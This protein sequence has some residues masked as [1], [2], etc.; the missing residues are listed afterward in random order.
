[1]IKN[2]SHKLWLIITAVKLFHALIFVGTDLKSEIPSYIIVAEASPPILILRSFFDRLLSSHKTYRKFNYFR[3][4]KNHGHHQEYDHV[5][6]FSKRKSG[7]EKAIWHW[8]V[9]QTWKAWIRTWLTM[10]SSFEV[11]S[12]LISQLW[13]RQ[14]QILST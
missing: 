14:L 7:F 11:D 5:L 8:G 9:N 6:P 1:M 2:M 10:T 3:G 12:N 4:S 13:F